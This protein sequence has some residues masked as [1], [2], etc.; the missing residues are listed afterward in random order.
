ASPPAV[1]APGTWM[2]RI[3]GYRAQHG[4]PPLT[5]D[6]S[7]SAVAHTWTQTMAATNNL[8]HNPLLAQQVTLPW[9]RLAENVGYGADEA[10]VFQAF[11]NSA[12]HRANL[13]GPFNGIGVG[14]VLS[15]GRLWTTHV[16]VATT[17]ALQPPAPPPPPPPPGSTNAYPGGFAGGIF[18]AAGRPGAAGAPRVITG[19]DTGGG[20]HVRVFAPD[21]SA[22]GGGF[23]AYPSGF[24]GGVR[25]AVYDVDPSSPGDEVI[26]APGPGGGPNVKVFRGDAQGVNAQPLY[27]F[28]AYDPRWAGGVYVACGDVSGD[29]RAE[30]I[31]GVGPGGGPNARVFTAN[32]SLLSSFWAYDPRF[33]GGVIVAAGKVDAGTAKERVITGVGPGG[34]PHVRTFLGNGTA[35]GGG[36]FGLDP[37]LPGGVFVS[38]G[39]VTGD[40]VDEIVVGAGA[41]AARVRILNKD[42]AQVRPDQIAFSTG[43][44][45]G[46]RVAVGDLPSGR[47]VAGQGPGSLP[48]WRLLTP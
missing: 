32:G 48:L 15:G 41:G 45:R 26:A 23:F 13:L 1:A 7:L 39:D 47:I 3:N 35:L 14:Q 20:P 46:A 8:A 44:E 28:W 42:G 37:S 11:V 27:S 19:A 17:A 31:T 10:S 36:F 43:T 9:T 24:V 5:E 34:G 16:F 33:V 22:M 4:L 30:I 38:A 29:A 21:G 25:V 40:G 2:A 12:P 18:V 6:V